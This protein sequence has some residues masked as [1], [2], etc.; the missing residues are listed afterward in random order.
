VRNWPK[1]VSVAK[2]LTTPWITLTS[3][4]N[5]AASLSTGLL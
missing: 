2:F 1:G 5:I 4:K 3:E